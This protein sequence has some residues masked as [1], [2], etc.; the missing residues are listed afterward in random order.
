MPWYA[1]LLIIVL[2][3]S[4]VG[5]G[6][7]LLYQLFKQ[8]KFELSEA[9]RNALNAELAEKSKK[10]Q[11]AQQ[12]RDKKLIDLLTQYQNNLKIFETTYVQQLKVIDDDQKKAMARYINDTDLIGRELDQLLGLGSGKS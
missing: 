10:I 7:A 6:I 4:T 5:L 12:D 2:G 8:P 9:E 11:V 3:F 1:W